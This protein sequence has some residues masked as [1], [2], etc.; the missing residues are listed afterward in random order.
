MNFQQAIQSGFANYA[1]FRG[2][3]V[4]SEY[5]YWTLFVSLVT[6]AAI[7]LDAVI[8][9]HRHWPL[10]I[11]WHLATVVPGFAVS[12]RRLHDIDRSGWWI[13]AMFIAAFSLALIF[14]FIEN[15]V[16]PIVVLLF[17]F[18]LL[19]IAVLIYWF[20]ELGTPGPNR[21]GPDPFG[22]DGHISPRPAI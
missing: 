1:N 8:V 22:A 17:F 2:R 11:I 14:F 21:Y 18:L 9:H 16:L 20:C 4:R 12:T 13:V 6:F 15:P 10:E 19:Y 5:W 7:A 3:A